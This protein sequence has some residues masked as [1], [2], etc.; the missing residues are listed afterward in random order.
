[1]TKLDGLV[2]LDNLASD[3]NIFVRLL[4]GSFQP[5]IQS[6]ARSL[7]LGMPPPSAHQHGANSSIHVYQSIQGHDVQPPSISVLLL[8]F[9]QRAGTLEPG[10]HRRVFPPA[11]TSQVAVSYCQGIILLLRP[12]GSQRFE[13]LLPAQHSARPDLKAPLPGRISR[14]SKGVAERAPRATWPAGH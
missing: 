5:S 14:P 4:V 13:G 2:V 11:P 1:M 12:G 8:C 3:A 10:N 9:I 6:R 7:R